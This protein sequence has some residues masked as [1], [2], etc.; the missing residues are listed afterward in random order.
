MQREVAP[1]TSKEQTGRAMYRMVEIG[2]AGGDLSG[3]AKLP[4]P[5]FFDRVRRI[6]YRRD[7]KGREVV[8][9]PRILL[10]E[11][12]ALDCKKKAIL[13][14]SWFR[15]HGIPFRFLAVSENPSRKFHHVYV[16]AKVAGKWRPVDATYSHYRLFEPKT[17]VTRSQVLR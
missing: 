11:F 15:A 14:A 10:S 2:F 13:M 3:A 12:S 17:R 16:I 8:A 9:R 6:P 5:S 7:Q 1:L 4:L